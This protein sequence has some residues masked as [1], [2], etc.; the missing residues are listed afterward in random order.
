MPLIPLLPEPIWPMEL[1]ATVASFWGT[2]PLDV[3]VIK[4]PLLV[5]L[6]G[7]GDRHCSPVGWL[8]TVRVRASSVST[9][10]AAGRPGRT[11]YELAKPRTRRPRVAS[12]SATYSGSHCSWTVSGMPTVERDKESIGT[13]GMAV[14]DPARAGAQ[15]HCTTL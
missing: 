8:G 14:P 6:C 9:A 3:T 5:G 2:S 7:H 11:P 13:S 12:S 1:V 4:L 10:I 15:Y